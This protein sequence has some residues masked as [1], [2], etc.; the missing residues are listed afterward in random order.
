MPHTPAKPF[1]RLRNEMERYR[2]SRREG[3]SSEEEEEPVPIVFPHTYPA[4]S[5]GE[6]RTRPKTDADVTREVTTTMAHLQGGNPQE[7]VTG[8]IGG[9]NVRDLWGELGRKREEIYNVRYGMTS[10][11]KALREMRRQKNDADNKMLSMFRQVLPRIGIEYRRSFADAQAL[12]DE[13]TTQ[14][15]LYEARE[16]ELD[17]LEWE[18]EVLETKFFAGLSQR[19]MA[20]GKR[21]EAPNATPEPCD[22]D[23]VPLELKGISRDGPPETIHPL[24]SR[25]Q[26]AVGDF[27]LASESWHEL[28]GA[29]AEIE[30]KL[31]IDKHLE[32]ERLDEEELEFLSE[33]AEEEARRLKQLHE[34]RSRV[35]HL[36]KL[37]VE[38]GAMRKHLPFQMIYV[39][40]KHFPKEDD[41]DEDI[42]ED[43]ELVDNT[44]F[45]LVKGAR[46][47][48]FLWR[49]MS[50]EAHLFGEFPILPPQALKMAENLPSDDPRKP[51]RIRDAQEE[52]FLYEIFSSC[53][54]HDISEFV[55]RW[56]LHQLRISP[57]MAHLW[58]NEAT[59]EEKADP[60]AW[61][62]YVL[63]EW[64]RD[65]ALP[66]KG[67][68]GS[69]RARDGENDTEGEREPV[70]LSPGNGDLA[71]DT[72]AS[73]EV[74]V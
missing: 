41:G 36:R 31:T 37:C 66:I 4:R 52:L 33:Y 26:D 6:S 10:D 27:G 49:L 40:R 29:R 72:R 38:Q 21:E 65:D 53:P 32:M 2:D 23:D 7:A 11:R 60:L 48:P 74:A 59:D 71:V 35:D 68:D 17:N 43:M 47:R 51:V 56:L 57:H 42:G 18:L 5:R 22:Q 63:D 64:W 8:K 16:V 62:E 20:D 44:P 34:T 70:I 19:A 58:Y 12:R 13:Y 1:G 67:P 14:E 9:R 25:F 15:N 3:D 46:A 69:T 24:Y 55:N 30:F 45:E 73:V 39:L 50:Q 54:V 28:L 61:Q